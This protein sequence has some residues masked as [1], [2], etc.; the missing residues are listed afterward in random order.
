MTN[1]GPEM[2]AWG[3]AT[4]VV[5]TNPW[6]LAAPTG[7]DFNVSLDIALTTAGKGMMR[8]LEREG[9]SMPRDWA[10]TPEG[11]ETDDPSAAMMGALLGIGQYKGYGLSFMTDVLTGVLSG[12]AFGLRPYANPA[13][14]DVAHTFIAFDIAWFIP[15]EEFKERMDGFIADIKKSKIRPGFKEILVPGELEQRRETERRQQGVYLDAS[16][17][18]EL[19]VLAKKLEINFPFESKVKA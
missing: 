7:L 1:A 4:A 15:L 6:A 8:W 17:F 2:A 14:Q 12:G 16:V 19:A 9:K 5:G 13:K 3:G 18:D 11:E 10:L